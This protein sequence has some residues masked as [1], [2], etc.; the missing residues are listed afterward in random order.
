VI[1]VLS[2]LTV[3]VFIILRCCCGV[4][5]RSAT[6]RYEPADK[7]VTAGGSL[8]CGILIIIGLWDFG[9]KNGG[10]GCKNRGF[11]SILI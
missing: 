5:G 3:L 9:V 7:R 4:C 11:W 10:C 6:R 2:F 8:F 1:G